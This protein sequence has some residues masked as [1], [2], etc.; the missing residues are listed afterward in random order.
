MLLFD[1]NRHILQFYEIEMFQ[2]EM[3]GFEQLL[4]IE[5]TEE[6]RCAKPAFILQAQFS[7]HYFRL[8][9]TPF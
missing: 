7:R 2:S 1:K 5:S 9:Y 3:Y 8:E 6:T 4:Q